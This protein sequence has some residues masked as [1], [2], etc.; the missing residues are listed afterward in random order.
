MRLKVDGKEVA[1]C[2]Y[3]QGAGHEEGTPATLR[4]RAYWLVDAG[5]NKSILVHYLDEAVVKEERAAFST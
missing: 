5:V 3:N 2:S 4:R 1:I